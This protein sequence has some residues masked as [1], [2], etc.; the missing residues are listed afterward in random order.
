MH[1]CQTLPLPFLLSCLECFCLICIIL[2]YDSL[3]RL[4][5]RNQKSFPVSFPS[6][7]TDTHCLYKQIAEPSVITWFR[8]VNQLLLV[9][10]KSVAQPHIRTICP[11]MVTGMKKI[12]SRI[13]L[14]EPSTSS[15]VR[16]VPVPKSVPIPPPHHLGFQHTYNHTHTY[17]R[18]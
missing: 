8:Y 14:Q 9:D 7:M 12:F 18:P 11:H 15:V 13:L 5:I 10:R 2:S 16:I 3:R 1:L 4:G 6:K 17:K